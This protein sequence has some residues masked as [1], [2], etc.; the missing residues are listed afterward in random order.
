[1]G[2][3]FDLCVVGGAGHVGLPLSIVFASAGQRVLIYDVNPESLAIIG[4]GRL[5]FMESGAEPLLRKALDDGLLALTSD[6]A[7][8]A[9]AA[10]L[11]VVIGT[12]ID[13]FLNPSLKDILRCLDGLLPYISDDQ[14]L[15]L[16]STVYPGVTEAV[17][18][19]L[20]SKGKYPKVSF[21]PERIVQGKAVQELLTLPQIV[22]GTTREAEDAAAL[23]F[24]TFA[25]E[26]VRMSPT[27]AEM[28]KL[29]S[30]A[31]R[32][33]QFATT[34]QFYLIARAAGVD[35]Y[36][37]LEGMKH[38]YPRMEDVPRAGFAAG[39]CLYKDTMQLASFYKNQF[40][41]G[42]AAMLVN[43]SMPMFVLD[44]LASRH[45]LAEMTVGLLGMAFKADN[46][47]SRSSLSYKLK[48]LVAFQAKEVLT[49]DPHV[50][51]D[52]ALLPLEEVISRSD[53]IILCVPHTAY[54][55]LSLPGKIVVD[56]WNFW[57]ETKPAEPPWMAWAETK[58]AA[59]L[60][61]SGR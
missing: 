34:N 27:E 56:I 47:D 15:I 10:A 31:Y 24:D 8:V 4:Q 49:T 26:I 3:L 39:P 30:N 1:M 23:L 20:A 28:V 2:F 9:A 14:L 6:P 40:S 25:P 46:D 50:T 57:G 5:P 51:A 17:A 18:K 36:R 21:C 33:I 11:V 59:T 53:I 45:P 55:G 7:Q 41:I 37:V 48:K 58:P 60:V 43:E 61:S 22:S 12:P 42:H 52:P 13:E 16:R 29:F 35:Y 54:K 19:Y 38:N 32:Y 44:Q